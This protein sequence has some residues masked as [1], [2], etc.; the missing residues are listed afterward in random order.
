V[1]VYFHFSRRGCVLDSDR[2]CDGSWITC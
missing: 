1:S 2:T